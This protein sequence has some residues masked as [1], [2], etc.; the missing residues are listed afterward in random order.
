MNILASYYIFILKL[1]IFALMCRTALHALTN[2]NDLSL[3]FARYYNV[4]SVHTQNI[5]SL[6]QLLKLIRLL[7]VKMK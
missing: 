1:A 3:V 6:S 7:M 2:D 4:S 5:I